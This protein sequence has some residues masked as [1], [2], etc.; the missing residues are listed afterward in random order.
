MRKKVARGFVTVV[1]LAAL[2]LTLSFPS[3]AKAKARIFAE[4]VAVKPPAAVLRD[5]TKSFTAGFGLKS[6]F[7]SVENGAPNGDNR[8]NDFSIQNLR[9]FLNARLLKGVTLTFNTD[10]FNVGT[11]ANS[12]TVILD[13]VA[14]F[15]FNNWFNV[16]G[17]RFH[18]PSDRTNHSGPFNLNAW[19]LPFTLVLPA[20]AFGRDNGAAVWG[21]TTN[22]KFKYE[23]GAFE[24]VRSGAR[25]Q[26]TTPNQAS[27]LLYAGKL[28]YNFWDTETGYGNHNSYFGKKDILA[29]SIQAMQQDGGIGTIQNPG[30]F[31]N[32]SVSFLLEKKLVNQA[33]I[34][35]DSA[36]YDYNLDNRP[37]ERLIGGQAYFA[38]LNYMFPQKIG[39]GRIQPY[40]RYQEFNRD[41][42]NR[43]GQRGKHDRIEGGFNYILDGHSAKIAL[44]YFSDDPGPNQEHIDTI[45]L[46]VQLQF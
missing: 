22:G 5:F 10:T 16:W 11:G 26:A 34:T 41:S 17:G 7:R 25:N 12:S 38:S 29:I 36:Y 30:R 46:G 3:P 2:T 37:D 43:V 8:L 32:W 33:V 20:I 45:K 28:Q 24:G 13:A 31:L 35:L 14:K 19:D 4:E 42:T 9:L 27:R 1:T 23:F 40:V 44:F 15:K 39:W 6:S 21:T 18:I